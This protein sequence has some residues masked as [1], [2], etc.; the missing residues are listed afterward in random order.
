V[1]TTATNYPQFLGKSITGGLLNAAAALAPVYPAA[2]TFVGTDTT[3]QGNWQAGYGGNGFDI[4]QDGGPNNPT[5]PPLPPRNVPGGQ[6]PTW[7]STTSDPRALT[8]AGGGSTRVAAAWDTPT[9]MAFNVSISDGQTHEL[10]LY[11]LDWDGAGGGRSER[12]DLIDN[13]S[14]TVL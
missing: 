5:L 6:P 13:S 7:S 9:S 12:I 2:A 1:E 14:G 10:A 11:A 3:T 8:P 4:S